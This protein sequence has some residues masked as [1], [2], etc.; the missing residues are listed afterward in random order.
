M[1]A[2]VAI[3]GEVRWI[4]VLAFGTSVLRAARLQVLVKPEAWEA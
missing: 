1:T 3:A 4:G 2:M